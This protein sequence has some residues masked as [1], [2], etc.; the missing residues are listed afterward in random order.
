MLEGLHYGEILTNIGRAILGRNC[1]VTIGRVACEA[2]STTWDLGTK[3]AFALGSRKT[4]ENLDRVGLSQD[5]PD[6]DWLL[7]SS[8]A[9]KYANPNI[10]PSICAVSFLG[11]K[12]YIFVAT[13]FYMCIPWMS[14]KQ[15]CITYAGGK[16]IRTPNPGKILALLIIFR[17]EPHR[18]HGSYCCGPTIPRP[19]LVYPLQWEAVY[20]AVA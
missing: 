2:C 15:L 9:F 17:H 1:D 11:E 10:S 14:S 19:L 3:S 13:F 6:A 5:P 8:P 16:P 18:K 12:A 7:A 4:T 20:W